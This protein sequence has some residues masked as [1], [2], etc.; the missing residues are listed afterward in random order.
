MHVQAPEPLNTSAL[1]VV[2]KTPERAPATTAQHS[3]NWQEDGRFGL[4]LVLIVLVVNVALS[5]ALP[6]IGAPKPTNATAQATRSLPEKAS[7]PSAMNPAGSSGVQV[8]SEPNHDNA[9]T[10]RTLPSDYNEFDTSPDAMP[11][12]KARQLEG[13][14]L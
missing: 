8:Y 6:F 9:M 12:P 10:L 3:H 7:M 5:F 2:T 4:A 11:A 13:D 14:I 1:P